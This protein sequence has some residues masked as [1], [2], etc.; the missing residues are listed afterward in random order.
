VNAVTEVSVRQNAVIQRNFYSCLHLSVL[1]I[2]QYSVT[3]VKLDFPCMVGGKFIV[4]NY[5]FYGNE[6]VPLFNTAETSHY[7]EVV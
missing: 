4:R 2:M 6:G 7:G 5:F 1:V 3:F